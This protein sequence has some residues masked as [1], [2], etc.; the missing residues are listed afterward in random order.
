MIDVRSSAKNIEMTATKPLKVLFVTS[1]WP[2]PDNPS[3]APFVERG[4]RALREAGVDMDVMSYDGGW[5]FGKYRQAVKEMRRRIKEND[6]DLVHAYFGQCGTVARAQFKLPMVISYGG[7]DVEGSP[8][9]KGSQRYKHYVLTTISR[10]ISLLATQVIVVSENLGRK[11]PRRDYHIV[12]SALDL[13]MFQPIDKREARERLGLPQ[14]RKLAL[15]ASSDPD[16]PRKRRELAVEVCRI[17]SQTHPIELVVAGKK[18]PAEIPLYMSACDVLLITSSNEGSPNVLKEALACNLPVVSTDV[19]DVRKRLGHLEACAVVAEDTP[20]ALAS[21]LVRVL[22]HKPTRPLRDEVL[23]LGF[24]K[25]AE[26]V[27]A[28]YKLATKQKGA[29]NGG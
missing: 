13:D 7:S 24:Q 27:I 3:K 5:S 4:V 22:D 11:L 29:S 20:G 1:Q 15:F 19:G 9:F 28:V 17:A 2:T 23:D 21:A 16:N 26:R 8:T 12:S 14:D 10:V 6:Y 25:F 18:P